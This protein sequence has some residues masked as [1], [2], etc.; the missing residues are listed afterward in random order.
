MGGIA[1]AVM[2]FSRPEY[3]SQTMR[4]LEE[5]NLAEEVDWHFFLDG[6]KTETGRQAAD[7]RFT[8]QNFKL[9]SQFKHKKEIHKSNY[10]LGVARNKKRVHELFNDYEQV[11]IF[12]EDMIVS[13]YYLDLIINLQKQFPQDVV[14]APARAKFRIPD[15]ALLKHI[16]N[17][18][19]H[20]WGYSF[21]KEVYDSIDWSIFEE[22]CKD[23]G[24]DYARRPGKFLKDKYKLLVS[25]HDG[26]LNKI[27]RTNGHRRICTLLPR[28]KYIGEVGLHNNPARYAQ[29]GFGDLK[30]YTY[31]RDKF[32]YQFE[33]YNGDQ[34]FK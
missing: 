27:F 31:K 6:P 25:S 18:G 13:P 29:A 28:G 1:C 2:A 17:R 7:P 22:Y 26:L 23:A 12:E 4:S 32:P 10:N 14:N 19:L 34:R 5:N 21:T 16:E 8:E 20:F 33:W 24:P 15:D 11:I 3:F 9:A 30:R